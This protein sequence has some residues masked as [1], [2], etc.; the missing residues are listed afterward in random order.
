VRNGSPDMLGELG[1]AVAA[2]NARAHWFAWNT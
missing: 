1:H 2:L